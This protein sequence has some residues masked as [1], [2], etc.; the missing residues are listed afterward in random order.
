MPAAGGPSVLGKESPK[1]DRPRSF[2]GSHQ[3]REHK[4]RSQADLRA[5][6]K[7]A[8]LN[9]RLT[10]RLHP[11]AFKVRHLAAC[12]F[13]GVTLKTARSMAD[14]AHSGGLS[15]PTPGQSGLYPV[16]QRC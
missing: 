15:W 16:S 4:T 11:G 1:R 10:S 12:S 9:T 7:Q 13:R 2:A 5:R 8:P 3:W 14:L 6:W